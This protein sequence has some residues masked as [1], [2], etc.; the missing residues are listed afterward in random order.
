MRRE[1]GF[2]ISGIGLLIILIFSLFYSSP[3]QVNI[4]LNT[5]APASIVW[6]LKSKPIDSPFPLVAKAGI[7]IDR[8]TNKVL[9]KRNADKVLPIASLTKIMTALIVMDTYQEFDKDLFYK[10]LLL[11]SNK[12]A[13]ELSGKTEAVQKGFIQLMNQRAKQLGMYKTHYEDVTGLSEKNVST[14]K[15]TAILLKYVSENKPK[16]LKVL[17]T[18][19][20]KKFENINELLDLPNVIAGKTGFTDEAGGCLG[21]IT[22][23][24]ISVVLGTDGVDQ[25]FEQSRELIFNPNLKH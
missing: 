17:G 9:Y 20:Y 3:E 1:L 11:S 15:E 2:I 22:K 21:L 25:R 13:E 7:L 12:A 14:A 19:K 18:K 5:S 24:Y 4:K 23:K 16:L 10:M 6:L 8:K